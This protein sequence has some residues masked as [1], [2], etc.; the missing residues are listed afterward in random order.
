MIW[1]LGFVKSGISEYRQSNVSSLLE[2]SPVPEPIDM[3]AKFIVTKS[4]LLPGPAH[5][6]NRNKLVFA[7]LG[8]EGRVLVLGVLIA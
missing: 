6:P 5:G 1:C 3:T 7:P 4:S 2:F 8:N